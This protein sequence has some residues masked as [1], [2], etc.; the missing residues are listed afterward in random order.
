MPHHLKMGRAWSGL[1]RPQASRR[2]G[3]GIFCRVARVV[4]REAGQLLTR[5]QIAKNEILAAGYNLPLRGRM[6]V[7]AVRRDLP[8]RTARLADT[9]AA[10]SDRPLSNWPEE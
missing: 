8:R 9:K 5:R 1:D 2:N 4:G 7:K 10:A 3:R 6:P